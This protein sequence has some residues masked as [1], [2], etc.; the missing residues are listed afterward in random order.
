MKAGKA[1]GLRNAFTVD[2][3]DYFQVFAFEGVVARSD[4]ERMECRVERNVRLILDLLAEH[5]VRGTFFVLGWIAERY[6]ELVRAIARQG[7]EIGSHGCLHERITEMSE[8]AFRADV[9]KSKAMLEDLSGKPVEG[10]RAPSFSLSSNNLWAWDVLAEAG[11][12][13]SSSLFPGKHDIYGVPC[14]PRFPFIDRASK[15]TEIPITTVELGGMRLSCGGGGFFR[16]WPYALFKQAVQRVNDHDGWPTVF[17]L[18]PWEVDPAQPR[19]RNAPV[20]SKF[21]HYLNLDAVVP[22]LRRLLTDFN[23]GPMQE[24]FAPRL[25]PAGAAVD[26]RGVHARDRFPEMGREE[27]NGPLVAGSA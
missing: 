9:V 2:V 12:R 8:G 5:D 18:H 20:R 27:L 10:Y 15:L 7:H 13:Y 22:R 25:I 17:Y 14:A 24:V 21:R 6:P 16:F 19:L 3:E 23:W 11:Y 4:W 1:A 26:S